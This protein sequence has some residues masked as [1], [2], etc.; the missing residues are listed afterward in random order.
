[1]SLLHLQIVTPERILLDQKVDS[2]TCTTTLGQITILPGHVPLVAE[3]LP[4]EFIVR[5]ASVEKSVHVGGGFLQINP[6]GQVIVLADI[7]EHEHEIDA[8]RAKEALERAKVAMQSAN[9]S[10]REFATTS[11]LLERNY[12]RLR[13]VR[14]RAHRRSSGITGEGVLEE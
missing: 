14:K 8:D 9:L 13:I 3:L 1:M 12:A 10:A 2:I 11:A 7:A 4:N 6:K 5:T